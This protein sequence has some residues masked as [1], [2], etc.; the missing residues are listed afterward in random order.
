MP[1]DAHFVKRAQDNS[2]VGLSLSD[3]NRGAN[4]LT[5]GRSHIIRTSL[6]VLASVILE[7]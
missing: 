2:L 6:T 5:A 7:Q 4:S 1:L 3:L